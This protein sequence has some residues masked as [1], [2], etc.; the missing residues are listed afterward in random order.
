MLPAVAQG[1]VGIEIRSGDEHARSVFAALDDADSARR[2]AAERAC[3]E[4]LDGSCRTPIAAL[5]ELEEGGETM[6]LRALVVMPDGSNPQRA[7]RRGAT[8]EAA[9][10]G[11]EAG[12][13][14][15][16]AAGPAFFAALAGL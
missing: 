4:V 15:R 3:L 12:E 2:V 10:L 14:L 11:R 5:A 7:E 1:A 13:E 16:A 9:A 6:H 8:A